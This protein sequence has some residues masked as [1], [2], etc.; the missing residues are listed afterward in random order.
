MTYKLPS[1]LW[2]Q[3]LSLSLNIKKFHSIPE[4]LNLSQHYGK[5]RWQYF[6]VAASKWFKCWYC[7]NYN[8][9]IPLKKCLFLCSMIPACTELVHKSD[10]YHS[11]HHRFKLKDYTLPCSTVLKKHERL[12]MLSKYL[13]AQWNNKQWL[14]F[15]DLESWV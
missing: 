12:K 3:Y 11:K 7:W 6:G 8:N 13:L 1:I 14:C 4:L 9:T 10:A 15:E 5:Y 2:R